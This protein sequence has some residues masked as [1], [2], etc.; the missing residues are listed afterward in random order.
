MMQ[1]FGIAMRV[2]VTAGIQASEAAERFLRAP[3]RFLKA[4]E[5]LLRSS[6]AHERLLP[7][8]LMRGT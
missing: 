5:K 7:E 3:E 2:V 4:R 8:R 6:E 1:Y